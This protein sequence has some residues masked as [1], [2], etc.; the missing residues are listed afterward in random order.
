MKE[1]LS[2]TIVDF[3]VA[4]LNPVLIMLLLGSLLF[5]LVEVFYQG[6]YSGR[7]HVVLG[8]FVMAVVLVTR[9]A[10]E[11]DQARA[12]AFGGPLAVVTYLALWRFVEFSGWLSALSPLL[13]AL[14]MGIVWW[15]AW[16]L[17]WDAA[18]WDRCHGESPEGL[19]D[20]ARELLFPFRK[21]MAPGATL[22]AQVE[23]DRPLDFQDE[24]G[25]P[26]TDSLG[27]R[28]GRAP[29]APGV[30]V[31]YLALAALPLFGLGELAVGASR[32]ERR[33]WL[34]MLLAVYLVS[35]FGLLL[36]TSFLNLRRYLRSRRVEMPSEIVPQW[37]L[38]GGS[39]ILAVLA[40]AWLVPRPGAPKMAVDFGTW[41]VSPRTVSSPVAFQGKSA[42]EGR[43]DH[44]PLGEPLT[45]RKPESNGHPFTGR[46]S[47]ERLQRSPAVG[48]LPAVRGSQPRGESKPLE[49][50]VPP[51]YP[52]AKMEDRQS[53]DGSAKG[54]TQEGSESSPR[55]VNVER[56]GSR[57]ERE[58]QNPPSAE[59]AQPGAR[60]NSRESSDSARS[61]E[62]RLGIRK[63]PEGHDNGRFFDTLRPGGESFVATDREGG[64][65]G[66]LAGSAASRESAPLVPRAEATGWPTTVLRAVLWLLAGIGLVFA[67]ML[68]W[69]HR[70][71]LYSWWLQFKAF[72]KEL[73]ENLFGVT[74]EKKRV[75]APVE[76]AMADRLVRF[77]DYPNPFRSGQASAMPGEALVVYTFRALEAWACQ[78]AGPR[79]LHQTPLE[80]ALRLGAELPEVSSPLRRLADVYSAVVYG[81]P[82]RVAGDRQWLQALWQV[83]EREAL[84]RLAGGGSA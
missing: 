33:G 66:Y 1:R 9:I 26:P 36:T 70:Q 45:E 3:V 72:C 6:Q 53:G 15:A 54:F 69:K 12:F 11:T 60:D 78:F 34:L 23:G 43:P 31:L 37:L 47:V 75:A 18:S 25:R 5:F 49:G 82:V 40:V 71:I 57:A 62:S 17:T 61:G 65:E 48:E 32:F 13:N 67:S 68:G 50:K 55:G 44:P 39:I 46:D 63:Q 20:S 79:E 28:E 14:M 56:E 80:F 51:S 27:A 76:P 21:G 35:G 38:A 74:L 8:L 42:R 73:L 30:W 52:A 4:A 58:S 41:L 24:K 81:P 19:W 77:A 64:K 29:H 10:I 84:R 2:P 7:L 59:G 16:R 83:M 22:E